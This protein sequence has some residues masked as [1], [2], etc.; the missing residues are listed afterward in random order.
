MAVRR[1]QLIDLLSLCAPIP[2]LILGVLTM[3]DLDVPTSVWTLNLAAG[4]VGL[5]IFALLWHSPW[6]LSRSAWYVA[7]IVSMTAILATFVANGVD[8][9]HRWISLSGFRLH[10]SAVVAPVII[11][12][13]TTAPGSYL[14][15]FTAAATAMLLALQPDAAQACSV[16][17]ACGVILFRNVKLDSRQRAGGLAALV[18]CSIVS[19]IRPDPLKPVRYV[20]GIFQ[21]VSARSAV[22]AVAAALAMLLLPIPFFVAWV[23]RRRG[24][25]LALGAY[26]AM[27]VIAP[28]WGTFPVPVMGYGVAPILGYYIALAANSSA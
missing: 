12:C 20:E 28:M 22:W 1:F 25:S 17:A 23:Q 18:A 21:I 4:A 14:M 10:A 5:L 9:V 26:V 16:A 2:A 19:L 6:P 8:G 11:A 15:I 3:R 7:T 13:V 27:A 24:L